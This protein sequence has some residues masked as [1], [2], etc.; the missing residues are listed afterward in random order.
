MFRAESMS[1][2]VS[3]L[4]TYFTLPGGGW[5]G[6]A[7]CSISDLSTKPTATLMIFIPLF[8]ARCASGSVSPERSKL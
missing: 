5:G 4:M 8:L 3:K 6:V 1:A 2:R 7:T